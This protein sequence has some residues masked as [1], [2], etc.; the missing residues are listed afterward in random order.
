M[1]A[2]K[3]GIA[4]TGIVTTTT[5]APRAASST[6]TA[7]APVSSA[8]AVSVWGP[9]ELATETSCPRAVSRRVRL[10]PMLPAP[11]MPIFM[12]DPFTVDAHACFY[13][14][15]TPPTAG[16]FRGGA[17]PTGAP[18]PFRSLVQVGPELVEGQNLVTV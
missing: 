17:Q 11:M 8:S 4:L 3:F 10:P 14:S 15:T 7:V 2:G 1:P 18:S 12:R 5:S 9:R 16:L 6:G 13:P